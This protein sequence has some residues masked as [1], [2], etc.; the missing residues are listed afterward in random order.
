MITRRDKKRL[1]TISPQLLQLFI[2]LILV[3]GLFTSKSK[4]SEKDFRT[5]K[6]GNDEK[7]GSPSY[8][9]LGGSNPSKISKKQ[10]LILFNKGPCAPVVLIPGITGSNLIAE[11]DCQTLQNSNPYLFNTCG[12][13]TCNKDSLFKPKKEYKLWLP[14][15]TSPLAFYDLSKSKKLCWSGLIGVDYDA[16]S[17]SL[18]YKPSPGVKVYPFGLSPL[19]RSASVSAC[20]M[21]AIQNLVPD[22]PNPQD[23]QYFN[24]INSQLLDMGYIPG[25]TLHVMPYDFRVNS[26]IDPL[27]KNFMPMM[28]Q[29]YKYTQKKAVV[30]AHSMGNMRFSEIM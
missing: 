18:R 6:K 17:S 11:I 14:S 29:I 28:S 10:A 1:N 27:Y 2:Y 7:L 24:S 4:N 21:K 23:A 13:K 8:I 15:V 22:V 5:F 20:G 25:L 16:T 12:W 26:Q 9:C 19:S 30:V 3:A